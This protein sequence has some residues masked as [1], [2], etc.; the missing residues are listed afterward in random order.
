MRWLVS[1]LVLLFAMVATTSLSAVIPT[2]PTL[3]PP[4][5][6]VHFSLDLRIQHDWMIEHD[7]WTQDAE[8]CQR[9]PDVPWCAFEA[10]YQANDVAL[11]PTPTKG[12]LDE[13]TIIEADRIAR[14]M[15]TYRMT[16]ADNAHWRS[17]A[18][19]VF[20]DTPWSGHCVDLSETT[21]D[22]LV[23]LIKARGDNPDYTKMYRLIVRSAIDMY[24]GPDHMVAAVKLDDGSVWIVGDTFGPAY[25]IE[26]SP[27]HL[28]Q[29]QGQV[30]E[31]SKVSEGTTWRWGVADLLPW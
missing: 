3:T 25:P 27:H 19:D 4:P 14:G 28:A 24:A 31:S 17:H 22:V 1:T 20:E 30:V 5:A 23:K 29:F 7:G 11:Y 8:Q 9:Q 26:R 12:A 2:I 13:A 16:R 6:V 21:L 18:A 15:W 10:A